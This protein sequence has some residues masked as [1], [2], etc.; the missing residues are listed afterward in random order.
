MNQDQKKTFSQKQI[1]VTMSGRHWVALLGRLC[2]R[3]LSL[4]GARAYH[5]ASKILNAELLKNQE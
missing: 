2:G 1:S 3:N 4:E 5:E